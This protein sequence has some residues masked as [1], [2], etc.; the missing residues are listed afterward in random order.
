MTTAPLRYG[1]VAIALHWLMALCIIGMLVLGFVMED[2]QPQSLRL[3]AFQFH[4]SLGFAILALA[5]FRLAWR[6][7][8]PAP[9]YPAHMKP[10]EKRAAHAT[11]WGFYAFMIAMPLSGWLVISTSS[12]KFPTHFFGLFRIPLI[13][14]FE[15]NRAEA[16]EAF[17]NVHYWLAVFA[18]TL[19][20]LHVGAALKHHFINRDTVLVRMLPRFLGA[21]VGR[22]DHA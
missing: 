7:M 8:H 18:I 22:R 20:V 6:L 19:L 16:H 4:K 11:H 15:A 5:V 12:N 9:A 17:E 13:P 14:G 10:W 3:E 2:L 1:R 21:A